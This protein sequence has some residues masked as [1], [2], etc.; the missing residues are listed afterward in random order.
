[1]YRSVGLVLEQSEALR[2]LVREGRIAIV[3]AM[4]DVVTAELELLTDTKGN[5]GVST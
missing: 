5:M 2:N 3:G 4:Y 1:M